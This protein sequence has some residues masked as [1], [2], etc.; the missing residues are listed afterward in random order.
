LAR[1]G[2][3]VRRRGHRLDLLAQR[4]RSAT[5]RDLEQRRARAQAIGAGSRNAFATALGRAASRAEGA[6]I[7]LDALDPRRVL[8]RGYA[9]VADAQG[10]PVT[11]VAALAADDRLVVTLQDGQASVEV[12]AIVPSPIA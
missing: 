2:E 12:E 8:A 11:S 3:A 9:L 10:H 7:R 4:L 6:A 5:R 1:P